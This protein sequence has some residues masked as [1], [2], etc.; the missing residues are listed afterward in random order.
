MYNFI[1]EGEM[2]SNNIIFVDIDTQFDFMCPEGKLYVPGAEGIKPDIKRLIDL[3]N[4]NGIPIISS[5]DVHIPDDP[6]FRDFPPHC[7]VNTTGV[8]KIK[9]T[10]TDREKVLI[11]PEE[12]LKETCQTLEGKQ[13]II[14]KNT[15]DIFSNK[16]TKMVLRLLKAKSCVVFGV[17]TEYCVK[18]AVIG[19]LH[20][21]WTVY[22]VEDAIRPVSAI[23]SQM[24]I[25]RMKKM[26]AQLVST[27]QIIH[28]LSSA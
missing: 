7:I 1:K 27:D 3:A 12:K 22:L 8:L 16:N 4:K 14:E 10:I 23:E 25:E 2:E 21:G 6:E 15:F 9:E 20:E 13:I 26:G 19:L 24:A 17:A 18:T 28:Q 5:I 11:R